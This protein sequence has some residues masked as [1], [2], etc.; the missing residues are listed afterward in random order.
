MIA[1][2][3][4]ESLLMGVSAN[5]SALLSVCMA[6]HWETPQRSPRHL[7]RQWAETAVKLGLKDKGRNVKT[8]IISP[9][10]CWPSSCRKVSFFDFSLNCTRSAAME[11]LLLLPTSLLQQP[12]A[13]WHVWSLRPGRKMKIIEPE[14]S[15]WWVKSCRRVWNQ[16]LMHRLV[17][18][19][20]SYI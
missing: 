1:M 8:N 20:V 9:A 14:A 18:F 2:E 4:K 6:F 10:L 11:R 16:P 5:G 19:F 12:P 3:K 13:W 17:F 7:I 15:W